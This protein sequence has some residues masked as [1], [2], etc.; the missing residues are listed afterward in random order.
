MNPKHI[1]D[2]IKL[3]SGPPVIQ[4]VCSIC[5]REFSVRNVGMQA[6]ANVCGN[7]RDG[8]NKEENER[9]AKEATE[10]RIQ[11]WVHLCPPAYLAI[12]RSRLPDPSRLDAVLA[13]ECGPRGLVLHGDTGRGKTRCAWALL[14]RE[15]ANGR[16]VVAMDSM[17]GLRYAAMYSES[18]RLVEKWLESAIAT[19]ILLL[20]D[21]FKT[22]LTDSFEGVIF[23]LV[24]QR[25]ANDRPVILTSNDTGTTL[26]G[27]MTQD[28]A[29]PLLRRLRE[30]CKQISF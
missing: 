24:D 13:W 26:A 21:V 10:R 3:T 30:H 2:A 15:F 19:D 14:A 1:A 17:A 11:A 5:G 7:C 4:K 28:R 25:I 16:S 9:E 27:R 23:T 6:Y 20:D 22:K 8:K 18:A 29:N 12:D